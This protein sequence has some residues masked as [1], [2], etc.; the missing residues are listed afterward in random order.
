MNKKI[1]YTE[2]A[3][4]C[5]IIALALGTALME[6]ANFGMS[7]VVAPA[8]ILYLRFSQIWS[9]ITF[10]MMEYTVQAILLIIMITVLRKFKTSYLFSFVTAVIYGITLDGCLLMVGMI[11]TD[12]LI[13]RIAF[14]SAGFILCATGVTFMFHTYIAPEVYELLVKE[15]SK[16]FKI[17]INKLKTCYDCVSCL[18]SVIMSFV[19]FGL[20]HFEGINIGTII[21][22]LIN[23]MTIGIISRRLE[24]HFIFRDRLLLRGYFE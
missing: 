3:Y 14:F 6:K 16:R 19:F 5:G 18:I 10:G 8:Y 20:F 12:I 9:F 22:A 11:K 17:N 15:V 1:F 24:K 13:W 23:G 21:C 7:M 2:T 4:I